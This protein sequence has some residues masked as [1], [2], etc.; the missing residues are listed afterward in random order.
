MQNIN[1]KLDGKSEVV[2]QK[3]MQGKPRPWDK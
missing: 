2:E 3:K 1:E